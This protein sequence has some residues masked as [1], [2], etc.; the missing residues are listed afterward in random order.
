[1]ASQANP[2][3]RLRLP[4]GDEWATE[5]ARR[6]RTAV[7]LAPDGAPQLEWR[8]VTHKSFLSR[9]RFD[10]GFA[11]FVKAG[12]YWTD[13]MLADHDRHV[14]ALRD[15]LDPAVAVVPAIY[16]WTGAPAAM[17]IEFL[18]GAIAGDTILDAAIDTPAPE[19][20]AAAVRAAELAGTAFAEYH[21]ANLVAP[22]AEDAELDRARAKLAR[23]SRALL[24]TRRML[25]RRAPQVVF[26]RSLCDVGLHNVLV[27]DDHVAFIDL[28]MYRRVA[29]LQRDLATT[30]GRVESR[31]T[32][33]PEPLRSEL[34]RECTAAVLRGY[35]RRGVI[36]LDDP[37]QRW[38][39]ELL[40]VTE[41]GRAQRHRARRDH[42]VVAGMAVGAEW[43][44]RGIGRV[45]GRRG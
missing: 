16:A 30:L 28:P 17:A 23:D 41:R 31:C 42:G 4:P 29:T 36:D 38:L 8:Q 21:A 10:D 39:L 22:D 7:G 6:G 26:A 25:A 20:T 37:G 12:A 9:Y 44:A 11:V 3:S 33:A 35:A 27:C 43:I 32:R 40:W 13:A 18:D 34:R 5:L 19:R 1:M 45:H 15:A 24:V 2:R 14:R